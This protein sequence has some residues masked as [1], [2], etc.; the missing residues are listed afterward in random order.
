[1]P[2]GIVVGDLGAGVRILGSMFGPGPNGWR[3]ASP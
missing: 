2:Y 1:V 3:A